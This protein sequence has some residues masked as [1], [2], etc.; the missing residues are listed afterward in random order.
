MLRR[1]T[2]VF[3]KGEIE[4]YIRGLFV[5]LTPTN[6]FIIDS[7]LKNAREMLQKVTADTGEYLAFQLSVKKMTVTIELL[8]FLNGNLLINQLI[9]TAPQWVM[10]SLKQKCVNHGRVCGIFNTF[11]SHQNS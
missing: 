1:H 10:V 3:S 8:K 4:R 2:D 7:F 6:I 5:N 11:H 9:H